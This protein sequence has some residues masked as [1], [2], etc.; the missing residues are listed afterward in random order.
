[1]RGRPSAVAQ[2]GE[3]D[4]TRGQQFD[5]TGY[6]GRNCRPSRDL[7]T[8]LERSLVSVRPRGLVLGLRDYYRVEAADGSRYWLFRDGPAVEGVRWF[9]H[10][11]FA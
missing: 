9:M 6:S 2:I 3:L 10:G 1:M 5:E 7:A 11:L 8:R 4:C